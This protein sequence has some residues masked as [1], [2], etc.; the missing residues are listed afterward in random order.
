MTS[1]L[2]YDFNIGKSR[3]REKCMA[4][5]MNAPTCTIRVSVPHT[6]HIKEIFHEILRDYYLFFRKK[7]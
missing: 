1:Q 6:F 2:F 5:E 3:G 4:Q 7:N